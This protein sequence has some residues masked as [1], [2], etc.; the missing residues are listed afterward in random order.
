MAEKPRSND[1][2]PLPLIPPEGFII[3][4]DLLGMIACPKVLLRPERP[5]T[6]QAG[7]VRF[8]GAGHPMIGTVLMLFLGLPS[9]TRSLYAT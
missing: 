4:G 3:R 8:Y 9:I 6:G 1:Q 2:G 7:A 5:V